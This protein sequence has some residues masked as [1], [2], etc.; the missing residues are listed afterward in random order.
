MER[1]GTVQ[2]V[3]MCRAAGSSAFTVMPRNHRERRAARRLAMRGI[4][5]PA[6]ALPDCW[7]LR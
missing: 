1:L 4:L 2:Q 5:V 7:T 3:V 6:P